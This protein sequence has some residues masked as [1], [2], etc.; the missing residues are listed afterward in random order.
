[1]DDLVVISDLDVV[2]SPE[3]EDDIVVSVD[4]E[5]DTI[6]VPE[7]GPPGLQ[8]VPGL[9]GADGNTIIYGTI[10]PVPSQGKD[11]DLYINTATH[12]IFGPKSGGGWPPGTSLI[13][14]VGASIAFVSDTPPT[15]IPDNTLWWESDT[16]NLYLWYNDGNSKQWV[17]ACPQPD[18]N[19]FLLKSGDTMTGFLTLSATPT[20]ALHAAN[21]G[22][23]D[24]ISGVRYDTAQ[25]LTDP[26]QVQARQNIYAAP[27]DALAFNGIQ[28]N[29]A[30]A[31]AQESNFA[32]ISL[33]T[34][35]VGGVP[36]DMWGA[37]KSGTMALTAQVV[38]D[39]PPGYTNSLKMTVTTALASLGA[40]DYV[41]PN[42]RVEGVRIAKLAWGTAGA[43]PLM[44]AFWAKAN[45][46]GQYSIALSNNAGNRVYRASYQINSAA[47]WEYKTVLV[48]G[49]VT[50]TWTVDNTI[51]VSVIFTMAAGSTKTGTAGWGATGE[52]AVAG[53][54]NGVTATSDFFQITG[55]VFYPGS[56]APIA[57]RSSFLIRSL[58][59]ELILCK[60]YLAYVP[61]G[62]RASAPGAS[63]SYETVIQWPVQMRA[64]PACSLGA[65]ALTSNVLASYP[66]IQSPDANGARF[67]MAS[68]GAGDVYWLMGYAK[69]DARL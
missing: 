43:L 21:K 28:I 52:V 61:T 23:V 20:S 18:P 47:T 13:G 66:Q 45:R 22:Y 16:G 48:P 46:P 51:G 58:A 8:G 38:A 7:Q 41:Y 63:A 53:Q 69:A 60:R 62:L 35:T 36:A 40:S 19:T 33:P 67:L 37:F 65:P 31:L 59:D 3:P 39:A 42:T 32:S 17:I 14:P 26:Q 27:L 9:A 6:S 57:A 15:G 5:A 11:G 64:V 1:M 55:V 34:G 30:M 4:A 10:D 25:A 44:I 56:D 12:F 54:V 29:G 49:D 68:N 2:I 24:G 50:G